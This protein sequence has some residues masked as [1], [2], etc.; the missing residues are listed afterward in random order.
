MP[1]YDYITLGPNPA[2][3]EM[4][5][6]GGVYGDSAELARYKKLLETIHPVP[7]ATEVRFAVKAF[8]HDFGSYREVCVVFDTLDEKAVAF[9][10]HVERHLPAHWT[11]AE[12]VPFAFEETAAD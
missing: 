1:R 11:D 9:A 12:V 4:S 2:E 6:V 5:P 7:P 10:Y 8:P 3:E